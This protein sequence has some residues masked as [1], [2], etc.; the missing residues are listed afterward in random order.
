MEMGRYKLAAT[1]AREKV[2][3]IAT[4]TNACQYTPT[5]NN[6]QQ[7]IQFQ[8]QKLTSAMHEMDL[9]TQSRASQRQLESFQNMQVP[10]PR[11]LIYLSTNRLPFRLWFV[12]CGLCFVLCDL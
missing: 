3:H 12:V 8:T 10:R 7:L 6:A 5:H 2:Y 11:F 9:K 1:K 4:F